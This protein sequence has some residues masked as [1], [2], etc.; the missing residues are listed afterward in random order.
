MKIYLFDEKGIDKIMGIL[1]ML[2]VIFIIVTWPD[3]WQIILSVLGG[4]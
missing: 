1:G 4:I 3:T 2:Y